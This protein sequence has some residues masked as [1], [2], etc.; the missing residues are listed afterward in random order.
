M[1]KGKSVLKRNTTELTDQMAQDIPY[2]PEV[3][4]PVELAHK[5]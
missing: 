3:I 2:W 5:Y 4:A 1:A